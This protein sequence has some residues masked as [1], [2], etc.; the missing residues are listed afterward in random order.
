MQKINFLENK[1]L[2]QSDALKMAERCRLLGKKIVFTNGCFD[3]L[4]VGHA[5]YLGKAKD[6]GD[7][8]FIGLN[9][10]ASVKRQGKKGNRPINTENSR[11][12]MLASLHVTDAIIL[13]DELTPYNLIDLLKPDVLV[14][15]SDYK[16][17]E[18][19][20]YDIIKKQGGRVIT[21]PFVEGF[22][23]S[24]LIEKIKVDI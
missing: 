1:I 4:H 17:E 7:F 6:Q 19:V 24:S 13:F 18:I 8:L 11:A 23:T 10:D 9:T 22:S 21:I 20:G 5:D 2:S 15:G 14:K 16:I 3:I 12:L